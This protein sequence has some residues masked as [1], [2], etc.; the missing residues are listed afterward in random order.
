[1]SNWKIATERPERMNRRRRVGPYVSINKRGEIAMNAEAF[2]QIKAPANVTLLCDP[3][4]GLIG[5]K[6]P[7]PRDQNFFPARPYGRGRKM[8]IVRAARMLKQFGLTIDQTI[9]CK[10]PELRSL[11][12]QPMLVISLDRNG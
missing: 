5:I 4:R 11:D 10:N 3:G 8:K 1:M 9:I 12:D 7:V 6:F 2:R